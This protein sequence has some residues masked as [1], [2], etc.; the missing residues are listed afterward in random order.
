MR[1]YCSSATTRVWSSSRAG[2]FPPRSL[3]CTSSTR[4]HRSKRRP[5]LETAAARA[6][7]SACNSKYCKGK[8]LRT[9]PANREEHIGLLIAAARRRIKQAVGELVRRYR[10]PAQQ[11]WV[12]VAV[13]ESGGLSL[14]ELAKR[15]RMDEPTASRVV[16]ALTERKLMRADAHPAD[17]RRWCLHLGSAGAPL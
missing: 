17:R 16:S 7:L 13:R 14:R 8:Y 3:R 2:P 6:Y 9:N 5:R 10:L 1:R 4:S 15:L 12:L 11:F